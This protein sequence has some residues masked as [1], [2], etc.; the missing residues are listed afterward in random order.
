MDSTVKIIATIIPL[1]YI[2]V[3]LVLWRTQERNH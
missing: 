2:L 3:H 1:A